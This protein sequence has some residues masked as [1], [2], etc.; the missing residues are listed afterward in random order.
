MTANSSKNQSKDRSDTKREFSSLADSNDDQKSV[1]LSDIQLSLE[2]HPHIK[3][4]KS[5]SQSPSR[6]FG[7]QRTMDGQWEKGAGVWPHPSEIMK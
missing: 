7:V 6:P 3:L 1:A 4:G 5:P 2:P